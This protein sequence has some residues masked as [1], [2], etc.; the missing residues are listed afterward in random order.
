MEQS[1]FD[2]RAGL[3]ERA[4]F[5]DF[6]FALDFDSTQDLLPDSQLCRRSQRMVERYV[7]AVTY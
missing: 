1:V 6:N 4:V 7:L 2:L 3:T 5:F